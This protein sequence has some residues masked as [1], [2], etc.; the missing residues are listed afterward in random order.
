[1]PSIE[2]SYTVDIKNRYQLAISD[3][4]SDGNESAEETI[5]PFEQIQ[6]LEEQ[7]AR[8]K[9]ERKK[10][11]QMEAKQKLNQKKNPPQKKEAAKVQE[12]SSGDKPQQPR[13]QDNRNRRDNRN[14]QQGGD[15]RMK[16]FDGE[17]PPRKFD[18][19]R[20]PRRYDGERKFGDRPPRRFNKEEGG[21]GEGRVDRRP[22]GG[23]GG[24]RGGYRGKR[25]F[26]RR[27]GN[28]QTSRRGHDKKEGAGAHNWG[29]AVPA[30]I[31]QQVEQIES[32]VKKDQ[33]EEVTQADN[34]E[35]EKPAVEEENKENEEEPEPV[36]YTLD[37]YNKKFGVREKTQF[38]TRTV[39]EDDKYA[40]YKKLEKFAEEKN[41]EEVEE[42]EAVTEEKL[43]GRK[44]DVSKDFRFQFN[45][46]AKR[47]GRGRYE[48][49]RG[50]NRGGDR[51]GGRFNNNQGRRN[52]G[53]KGYQK[54]VKI[55]DVG[56][57]SE[58]P[59]LA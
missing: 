34:V 58:F 45:T 50:G 41:E 22:R 7:R 18:G 17:R 12:P 52:E 48:D 35:G 33:A 53:N 42:V 19:E 6:K 3:N 51:R 14:E 44:K 10:Q 24:G 27:S 47:G 16:K 36:T 20:P 56:N 29:E 38:N 11:K 59:S 31:E 32:D 43:Q 21:D 9:E 13:R 5:D 26:D 23:R 25:E 30:D 37:E 15:R 1:M 2:E 54:K 8:E 49:N 28:D 4:E 55:P 39:A 46:Q 57:E 40:N